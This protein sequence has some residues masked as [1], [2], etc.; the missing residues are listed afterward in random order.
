MTLAARRVL[1]VLLDGLDRLA[2]EHRQQRGHHRQDE[3]QRQ[4][5]QRRQRQHTLGV[6]LQQQRAYQR[7]RRQDIG[8]RTGLEKVYHR[9]TPFSVCVFIAGEGYTKRM[10][11]SFAW[12]AGCARMNDD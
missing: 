11:L 1:G 4:L 12:C 2:D 5:H 10:G 9:F 3:R 6:G 7:H 8:P